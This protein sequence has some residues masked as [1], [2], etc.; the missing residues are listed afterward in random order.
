MHAMPDTAAVSVS[1]AQVRWFRAVRSHL[2]GPG[3]ASVTA[4]AS[5]LLGAQSQQVAPSLHALSLRTASRPTAAEVSAALLEP[6]RTLVRTWGPRETV[7]LYDPADWSL[8]VAARS[9][10]SRMG[11]QGDLPDDAALDD[12]LAAARALDEDPT[13]ATLTGAASPAYVEA[14]TPIASSARLDPA[15]FAAGRLLWCLALRG[16]M[17]AGALQGSSQTYP[18]RERWFPDLAWE[19]GD[20]HTAN[21]ALVRRY[22]SLFGPA[23]DKDVAHYFGAK[24]T[25]ARTWIAALAAELSPVRCDGLALLALARDRE[26]LGSAPGPWPLRLLPRFDTMLMAHADKRWTV[27]VE[28]ERSRVWRKG[29]QVMGT[30]VHRGQ[31][32]ATWSHKATRTRCTVMVEPLTGWSRALVPE[33]EAEARALAAHL[34]VPAAVVEVL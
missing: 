12:A 4:A 17:S 9:E 25:V 27:P 6:P 1:V 22:L 31:V 11:R 16:D 13:R 24:V 7:H 2:V 33:V 34:E 23:S 10:W 5:D 18:L 19:V 20:S 21:V 15:T 8:V 26:A 29:A 14:I 28:D 30:V 32:V 3:A